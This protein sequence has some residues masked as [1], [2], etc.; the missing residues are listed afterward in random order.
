IPFNNSIGAERSNLLKIATNR[1]TE[2]NPSQNVFYPRLAHGN[3]EN[4]NN[5]VGST[6]WLKSI[7]F[8]RLKTI[9]F[10]YNLPKGTFSNL[11]LKN[12]RVYIQGV[13][14]LYWSNFKLWDPEL[15]TGNGAS[16]PN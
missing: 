12:A 8:V 15:N 10:G 5:S 16:Y 2:D 4:A 11:G 3:V 6:W 13:N 14:L 7:D 1:W 9:D